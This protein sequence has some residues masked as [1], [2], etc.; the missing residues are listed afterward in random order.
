MAIVFNGI[1]Q[2]LLYSRLAQSMLP[3]MGPV[4]SMDSVE[5]VSPGK[6]ETFR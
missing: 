3:S 5:F 1:I 4:V 2:I 6:G